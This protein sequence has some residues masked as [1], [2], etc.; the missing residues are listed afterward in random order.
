MWKNQSLVIIRLFKYNISKR[1]Y[2][3]IHGTALQNENK[4]IHEHDFVTIGF[5]ETN[6]SLLRCINCGGYY[7][8][9]CGKT[10]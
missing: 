5:R 6:S 7:C 4:L 1:E 3:D 9:L 10:L 8:D 2:A